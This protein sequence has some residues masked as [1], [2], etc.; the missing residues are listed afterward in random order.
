[1]TIYP[2]QDAAEVVMGGNL[3]GR[4]Y[5]SM[6]D[7]PLVIVSIEPSALHLVLEWA[8]ALGAVFREDSKTAP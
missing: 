8:A 4:V 5:W 3:V 1:M 2:P 6:S 7:E